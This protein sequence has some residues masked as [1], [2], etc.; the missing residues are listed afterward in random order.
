MHPGKQTV[1]QTT[2]SRFVAAFGHQII[3]GRV[4]M[5]QRMIIVVVIVIIV[6]VAGIVK[7]RGR[8]LRIGRIRCFV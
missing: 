2:V 8:L 1:P 4:R 5:M 3:R 6:L 7:G